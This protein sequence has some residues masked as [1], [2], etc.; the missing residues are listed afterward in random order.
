MI[1]A[2]AIIVDHNIVMSN[3]SA[4]TGEG[5]DRR[6]EKNSDCFLLSSCVITD[7]EEVSAVVTG[8]GKHSQWGKIKSNLATESV[9]TPLQDKLEQMA[10]FVSLIRILK[11]LSAKVYYLVFS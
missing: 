4:L 7:G 9:K 6:K 10:A 2:D 3:E 5:I 11:L 8:I 1:P